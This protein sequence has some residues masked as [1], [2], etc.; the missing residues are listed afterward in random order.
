MPYN[1]LHLFHV[2]EIFFCKGTDGSVDHT[3]SVVIIQLYLA[4]MKAV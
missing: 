2:L 1:N 3:V 4:G